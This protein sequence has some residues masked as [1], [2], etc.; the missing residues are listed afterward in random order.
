M[1]RKAIF[2][3]MCI[4]LTVLL[5]NQSCKK[6]STPYGEHYAFTIPTAVAPVNESYVHTSETSVDLQ[7]ATTNDSGDPVNADVYFGTSSNPP[8]YSANGTSLSTSVP[9][10]QGVTY[11]WK[12]VMTDANGITT[13]SPVF[14]FTILCPYINSLTVGSYHSLSTPDQWNSEGDITITADAADPNTVY[15]SGLEALEGVDE[16]RGPLVMHI[17]PASNQVVA[18][19]TVLATDAFGYTNL[20]Y[21]GSGTYNACDGSYDMNFDISTTEASFGTFAFKFTRNP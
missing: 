20:A 6:T 15:V 7:W 16:N 13:T 11:Y 3:I 18:D 9:V 17:D 14:S 5:F 21:S 1:K 12:V 8:L 4:C 2:S 10:T 19:F